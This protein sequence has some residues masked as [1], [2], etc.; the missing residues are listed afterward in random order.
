[1]EDLKDVIEDVIK[2]GVSAD[3]EAMG[4]ANEKTD[5]DPTVATLVGLER[6][7]SYPPMDG[8]KEREEKKERSN[9]EV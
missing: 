5:E 4:D 7:I 3:S 1:M 6:K 9:K 8:K 2:N